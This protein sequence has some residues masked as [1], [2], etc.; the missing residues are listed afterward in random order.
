ML[1]SASSGARR[2][3]RA[4]LLLIGSAVALACSS[5]EEDPVEELGTASLA[6][7][8]AGSATFC[9]T[10]PTRGFDPTAGVVD[11]E[12]L[13]IVEAWYPVDT[14]RREQPIGDSHPLRRLLSRETRICCCAR[15]VRCSP[16]VGLRR[17]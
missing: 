7:Y 17:K 11:G 3:T 14:R 10:D 9:I 5:N 2:T 6:Q 16:T 4:A 13:L 12:R 1:E 15:S 8:A